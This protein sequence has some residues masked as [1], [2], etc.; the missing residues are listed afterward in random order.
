[1]PFTDIVN[2]WF[3]ESCGGGPLA[4]DT[5]AYNQVVAALP[6]LVARLAA[7]APASPAAGDKPKT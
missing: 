6:D 3:T 7:A 1:M 2:T 4:R 5:E